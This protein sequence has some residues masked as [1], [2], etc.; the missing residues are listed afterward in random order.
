MFVISPSAFNFR[1]RSRLYAALFLQ[2]ARTAQFRVI[3]FLSAQASV[4]EVCI[5]KHAHIEDRACNTARGKLR[6][7]YNGEAVK[8]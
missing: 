5:N 3:L 8:F 2:H 4:F 6:A 1:I 7:R